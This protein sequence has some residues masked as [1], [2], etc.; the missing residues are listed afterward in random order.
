MRHLGTW[1]PRAGVLV[2]LACTA[3]CFPAVM[4]GA[5][6]EEGWIAGVTAAT[7]S[8]DTHTEGDEGGIYLRQAMI[9]PFVGYGSASSSPAQPGYYIG[10]VVPV[11]YPFAQIDA[12]LEL[13]PGLTRPVATGVGVTAS[14]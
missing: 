4:H 2:V 12:Y 8:G 9:G 10:A 5:H 7:T 13:P 1:S 11:I 14:A 3:G 6:I